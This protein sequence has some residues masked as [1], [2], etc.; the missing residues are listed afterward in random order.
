MYRKYRNKLTSILRQAKG[1]YYKNRLKSNQGNQKSNW[2]T[3]NNILGRSS[4][5]KIN[6][7]ELKHPCDNVS[8]KFN[9]NFLNLGDNDYKRN[10]ND[11]F[12]KYLPNAHSF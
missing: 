6:Q 3:I 4:N 5:A 10:I 12:K 1:N 11:N 8:N 7:I 2:K 9:D